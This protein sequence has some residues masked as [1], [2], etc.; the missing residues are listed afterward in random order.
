MSNNQ[1]NA[2]KNQ[3]SILNDAIH[4]L[5]ESMGGHAG[6]EF[7]TGFMAFTLYM[8]MQI[9][10]IISRHMAV[11][12]NIPPDTTGIYFTKLFGARGLVSVIASIMT[13]LIKLFISE[14]NIILTLIVSSLMLISRT[15]FLFFLY[16]EKNRALYV[17]NV[18]IMDAMCV[19]LFQMTFYPLTADYVS[20]IS[21]CFKISRLWIFVLQLIM[22]LAI[23][24]KPM[25]IVK[26]HYWL[27]YILSFT[28]TGFWFYFCISRHNRGTHKRPKPT[29]VPKLTKDSEAPSQNTNDT[30]CVSVSEEGINPSSKDPESLEEKIRDSEPSFLTHLG[31]S[32]SPLMMCLVTLMMKNILFPGLLPYG[33][34]ERDKSHIVN[35][36]ITPVGL[37]GTSIVHGLKK[38]VASINRRWEWYW[39]FLWFLAIPPAIIFYKTLESLHP[40]SSSARSKI[41]NNRTAVLVMALV[42][43]FC[44][45]LIESAGYLGVVSNVKYC[46]EV[47]ERGRKMVSTNQLLGEIT[48]FIFYKIAVGYNVTRISLGYHLPK[49]RPN[50]RMSRYNLCAYILR[51]TFVRGFDDFIRDFKMNIRD[52]I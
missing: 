9:A 33:L 38:N 29:N 20:A 36:F 3:T 34:L 10:S 4:K 49:F 19:G 12:L 1:T 35:M 41:I 47:R 25:L 15:V 23:Y 16:V 39:H 14:D 5:D 21:L 52:Y 8:F 22:D 44:H 28:S 40:S 2:A 27:A 30:Q 50:H 46:N 18:L 42:F 31:N 24:D 6:G 43:H 37:A 32:F 51:E 48:H 11:A 13:Y 17:Y 45:S 7:I 26:I